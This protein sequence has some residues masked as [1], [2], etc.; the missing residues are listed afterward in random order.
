MYGENVRR[1]CKFALFLICLFSLKRKNCFWKG[2]FLKDLKDD[3]LKRVFDLLLSRFLKELEEEVMNNDSPIWQEETEPS[4]KTAMDI[5]PA[6]PRTTND[7]RLVFSLDVPIKY[8]YL[9]HI[10]LIF[11]P[12]IGKCV[13]LDISLA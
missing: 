2:C 7:T 9:F 6:S 8:L 11:L 3:K 13:H 4:A 10:V 12:K 1:K 5:D